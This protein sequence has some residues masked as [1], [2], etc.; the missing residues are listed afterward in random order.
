MYDNGVRRV[1]EPVLRYTSVEKCKTAFDG[2][3]EAIRIALKQLFFFKDKFAKVILFSDSQ[4]AIQA[5]CSTTPPLSYEIHQCRDYLRMSALRKKHL[6]LQW[7]PGHYGVN[8]NKQTVSLSRRPSIL[9]QS[10]CLII[11]FQFIQLYI[12][13]TIP[14][15]FKMHLLDRLQ[16]KRWKVDNLISNPNGPRREALCIFAYQ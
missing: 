3:V 12:K 14:K 13:Y 15:N 2:K 8:G 11:Y 16:S 7:I 10:R 6:L 9:F 4:A 1:F 5:I